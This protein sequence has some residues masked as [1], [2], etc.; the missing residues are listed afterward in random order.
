MLVELISIVRMLSSGSLTHADSSCVPNNEGP[1]VQV[2]VVGL[3]MIVVRLGFGM[4]GAT[5]TRPSGRI[6]EF[7]SRKFWERGGAGAL[8]Q[9]FVSGS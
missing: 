9:T 7:E 4:T 1:L 2:L 3:K 6:S 5:R 8:V